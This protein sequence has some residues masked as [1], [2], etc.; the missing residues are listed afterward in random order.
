MRLLS[1]LF[2]IMISLSLHG[3]ELTQIPWVKKL[4]EAN[5]LELQKREV[6]SY[7]VYESLINDIE[8]L[9]SKS[10]LLIHLYKKMADLSLKIDIADQYNFYMNKSESLSYNEPFNLSV[11]KVKNIFVT[12]LSPGEESQDLDEAFKHLKKY[13]L[14]KTRDDI[15]NIKGFFL[16]KRKACCDDCEKSGECCEEEALIKGSKGDNICTKA[17]GIAA[18]FSKCACGYLPSALEKGACITVV[19]S[20]EKGMNKCCK[21][22]T[23]HCVNK[24]YNKVAA[25]MYDIGWDFWEIMD[26]NDIENRINRMRERG[27]DSRH[28]IPDHNIPGHNVPGHGAFGFY[29]P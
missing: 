15:A 2:F 1:I 28:N 29:L 21:K 27:R 9:D 22:G 8:K 13:N 23:R 16:M 4:E 5:Q 17:V 14:I 24:I 6:D 10:T 11:F 25:Y 7:F 19:S 12:P 20:A 3:E 26:D 18:I